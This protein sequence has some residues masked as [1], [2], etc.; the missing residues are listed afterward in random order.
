MMTNTLPRSIAL[1]TDRQAL[2][3]EALYQGQ[4]MAY[5]V[6]SGAP[7]DSDLRWR[8]WQGLAAKAGWRAEAGWDAVVDAFY[9][10][11]GDQ[12]AQRAV[13]GWRAE[14]GL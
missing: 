12:A 7:D 5:D 11:L 14:A 2:L 13:Q 4:V 3:R 9:A 6:L 10:Q 1:P 8:R